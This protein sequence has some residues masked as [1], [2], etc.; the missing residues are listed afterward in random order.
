M[1]TVIVIGSDGYIGH[2]LIL[3]LLSTGYRVI[4]V[5]DFQRRKHGIVQ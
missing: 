2:A 1:K 4:A 3:R 5:D